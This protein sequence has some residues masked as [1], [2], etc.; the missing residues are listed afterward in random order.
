[1]KVLVA[2]ASKHGSTREIAGAIAEELRES[3]L[4]ADL[5]DVAQVKEID[6]YDAIVLGSGIYMGRWL[7]EAQKFVACHHAEFSRIPVWLFS[8]GPLGAEN[9]QPQDDPKKLAAPMG[10]V[11]PRDHR[12]FVGKLD[13]ATLGLV[14]RLMAKAVK[15]PA[16]DFRNW[17]EIRQWAR[18]IAVELSP[19]AAG[20]K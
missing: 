9:P 16:G 3:N 11:V 14:E 17:D 20:V 4:E 19:V 2:V 13:T 10:W 1:V 18:Q 5:R 7:P 8:S 12:V 15:A 6:A